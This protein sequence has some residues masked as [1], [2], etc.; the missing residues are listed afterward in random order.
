MLIEFYK[1]DLTKKQLVNFEI[2]NS[3]SNQIYYKNL[4]KS[5]VK[6]ILKNFDKTVLKNDCIKIGKLSLDLWDYRIYIS[7]KIYGTTYIHPFNQ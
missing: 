3:I 5:K 2:L 6:K 4:P 1:S 7:H